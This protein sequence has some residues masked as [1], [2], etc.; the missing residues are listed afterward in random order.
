MILKASPANGAVSEA[1]R[2][3]GWPSSS[4]FVGG[5]MPST[6]GTSSGEGR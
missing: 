4:P 3:A 1:S 6:G 5:S 2:V